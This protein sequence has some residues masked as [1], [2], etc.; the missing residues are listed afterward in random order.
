MNF[1]NPQIEENNVEEADKIEE[2]ETKSGGF[3]KWIKKT[4]ALVGV[5]G[6]SLFGNMQNA[7]AQ[8]NHEIES[9]NAGPKLENKEAEYSGMDSS[10]MFEVV[11]ND[12]D[13]VWGV[14]Y[15]N[16]LN[17]AGNEILAQRYIKIDHIDGKKTVIGEY[18]NLF[19]ASEG[20]SK[21][22]DVPDSIIKLLEHDLG[23]VKTE[24][25]FQASGMV[26]SNNVSKG[27]VHN[28]TKEFKGYGIDVK[29][30]VQVDEDGRVVGIN[31]FK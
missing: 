28:E 25:D 19:E 29:N 4:S 2:K 14:E 9:N 26:E 13:S 20:L 15:V 23:A 3:G 11:Y 21:I 1:E 24:K 12:T 30:N 10:N 17:K 22:N 6:V 18:D 7:N 5:A 27:R 8:E 31:S 16:K